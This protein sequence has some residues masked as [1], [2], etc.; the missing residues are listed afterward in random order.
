VKPLEKGGFGHSS[1]RFLSASVYAQVEKRRVM[2]T[3][4]M[5]PDTFFSLGPL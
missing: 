2:H 1:R 4:Y 3:L 5:P